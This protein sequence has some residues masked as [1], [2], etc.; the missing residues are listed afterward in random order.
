MRGYAAVALWHPKAKTNYGTAL[1][2]CVVFG[3]AQIQI[4]GP[5]FQRQASDTVHSWAK[6][7]TLVTLELQI[8]YD[9]IPVAVEVDQSATV[10]PDFAH[11]ERAL[12]VFGPE[13]GSLPAAVVARCPRKVVIPGA[14]CLN[15]A[16]AVSV[17]LY[18]RVAKQH[19]RNLVVPIPNGLGTRRT[20]R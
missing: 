17:V 3:V 6:V 19:A 1:R 16:A 18:D 14:Y 4:V 10:L 2:S 20:E 11:P 7:P 13:D 12:Y 8:P 9:C 15:L 5:R